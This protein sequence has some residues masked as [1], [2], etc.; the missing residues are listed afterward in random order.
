MF[1]GGEFFSL[2]EAYIANLGLLLCLK[3]FKKFVMVV[4]ESDFSVK[5]WPR[6]S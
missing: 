5:L 6:P 1:K 4:V 2:G 3:P